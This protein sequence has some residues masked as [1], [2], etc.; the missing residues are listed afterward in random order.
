MKVLNLFMTLTL[1]IANQWKFLVKHKLAA[2]TYS[3][4]VVLKI[5][6]G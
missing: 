2:A 5:N 1:D 3:W 4:P 6:G